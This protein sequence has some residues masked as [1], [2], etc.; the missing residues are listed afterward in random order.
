M[1]V[2]QMDETFFKKKTRQMKEC[3]THYVNYEGPITLTGKASH[4][5]IKQSR[6]SVQTS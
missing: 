3:G 5:E 2:A 4:L 1:A 6:T